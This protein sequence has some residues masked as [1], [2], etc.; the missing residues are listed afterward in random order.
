MAQT[1]TNLQRPCDNCTEW[2]K[3]QKPFK[4]YGNT[5]YVGPHG[6]SSVLLTSP[7]GHILI[8]GALA[9]S[10][11]LIAANIRSLGF[12]LKDVKL[13][14][15]SHVHYDHGGGVAALQRLSGAEIAASPWSAEVLTKSG[16]G[17]GDPQFTEL[18]PV[19]LVPHVRVVRD[20]ETLKIAGLEVTAHFTPGHTPGG[21][22]WTWQS[23]ERGNCL[24]M[25]YADSLSAISADN[26]RFSDNRTYPNAVQD[27]EKSFAFLRSTPCDVLLTPHP[28]AS[29]LWARLEQR[30]RGRRPGSM[31]TPGACKELA[32]RA[33]A[34]LQR[35]LAAERR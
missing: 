9:E 17:S 7:Q 33:E 34:Q 12:R 6:L 27:F 10:A 2:N 20:G 5:Y 4:V 3:S 23:C 22:S 18:R 1:S 16:I 25:V 13:I 28:E 8:D 15:N 30:R 29:G 14:V 19:A 21:T 11:P 32:G 31:L 26:F 35:R 24:N